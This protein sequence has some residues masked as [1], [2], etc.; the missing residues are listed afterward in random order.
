M[1]DIADCRVTREV[2][3]L[4]EQ[5]EELRRGIPHDK[6]ASLFDEKHSLWL[7]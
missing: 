7:S 2:H 5:I 1:T 6:Q 3:A 4:T